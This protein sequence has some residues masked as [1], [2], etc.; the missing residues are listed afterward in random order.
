MGHD[1]RPHSVLLARDGARALQLVPFFIRA[2]EGDPRTDLVLHASGVR[3]GPRPAGV[4]HTVPRSAGMAAGM[5]LPV[6][7]HGHRGPEQ[8]GESA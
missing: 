5:D 6:D 8:A 1:V 7:V 3:D 4:H 2:G